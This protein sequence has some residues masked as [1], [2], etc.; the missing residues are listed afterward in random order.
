M[1]SRFSAFQLVLSMVLT[2]NERL[3]T[4]FCLLARQP[5]VR[6]RHMKDIPMPNGSQTLRTKNFDNPGKA[7]RRKGLRCPSATV[8]G[9]I[10]TWP[11]WRPFAWV[12]QSVEQRTRNAQ[13]VGS[14]PT[15]GSSS[16]ALFASIQRTST[17][18]PNTCPNNSARVLNPRAPGDPR[19]GVQMA[20]SIRP[21]PD[22]G[23]D[24][25]ELRI[26]L[27]RDAKGRIRHTSK[28]FRGSKRAAEKE[29]SRLL[30][31]QELEPEVPTEAEMERW[32]VTTTINDAIEGWRENGWED[33]SPV[34]V[35]RYENVWKVHIKNSIGKERI[36]SL[37]PYEVERY[38]RRLKAKGAGR[39]T[40]RYVR[41]ILNRSCRLARKWS[42][43]RL[44][45]PIADT[46][47]PKWKLSE[48]SEP[49]RSP[50]AGEVRRLLAQACDLD[51]RYSTCLRVIAA[52]GIRRGEACALRWSDVD[53]SASLLTIDESVIAS[54]GG[55]RV[56]SPKTRTSIRRVAVDDGT[57]AELAELRTTQAKL[58]I[59]SELQLA[60]D[61]FVFSAEPGGTTPPYPDSVTHAFTK[62]RNAAG[63]PKD[64]H[65]HSLRHFQAT[66]LDT[67]IPERQ[68]QARLGWSTS[69]MARHYTDAIRSVDQ[70]AATHIG[71]ILDDRS[72]E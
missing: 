2:S 44:P 68:K 25:W 28:L 12:A 16:E 11:R 50:T 72:E 7:K 64:L 53:W 48:T 49:V 71:A 39:E 65:L 57:L 54:A 60:D 67:V 15:S 52:T 56:K 69:H 34:T 66:S 63:L 30:V 62:T 36:S 38:F 42:G 9:T 5:D 58:A 37:T 51:P 3:M 40:V 33:L 27:G 32:G 59:D 46:E 45:N 14:N 21:R 19:Y 13:V 8:I 61:G 55:A 47:L 43:N 23:A 29:L 20:G 18:C 35:Q 4:E 6:S 31:A 41:S 24:T 10:P 26:F 70:D 17:L 22:R 1:T